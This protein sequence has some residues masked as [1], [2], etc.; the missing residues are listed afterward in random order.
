MEKHK[1]R[2]G[3]QGAV[4]GVLP[5][6]VW[7]GNTKG[8][9]ENTEKGTFEHRSEGG[10]KTAMGNS[11]RTLETEGVSSRRQEHGWCGWGTARRPT[12]L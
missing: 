4:G 11:W 1:Q 7:S 6:L 2:K 5:H 9:T 3:D 10:S 12:W 8:G